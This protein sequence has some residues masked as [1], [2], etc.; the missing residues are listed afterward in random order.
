MNSE[1]EQNFWIEHIQKAQSQEELA[2][3]REALDVL[4]V[5]MLRVARDRDNEEYARWAQDFFT[6][7][8]AAIDK[9]AKQVPA[10]T[11]VMQRAFWPAL[12]LGVA[13]AGVL[14]VVLPFAAVPSM[15]V[16]DLVVGSIALG[17]GTLD[18]TSKTPE[19]VHDVKTSASVGVVDQYQAAKT[20]SVLLGC[21]LTVVGGIGLTGILPPV[22]LAIAAGFAFGPVAVDVYDRYITYKETKQAIKIAEAE[23]AEQI[24][25][26]V[27]HEDTMDL[28]IVKSQQKTL[29]DD[30]PDE[31]SVCFIETME[32]NMFAAF[33][34]IQHNVL[35][36]GSTST[37]AIPESVT[38]AE[39]G[40][41]RGLTN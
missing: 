21:G 10:K 13:V 34:K 9:R 40:A 18:F 3:W 19:L 8:R 38:E 2:V 27:E 17:H 35:K 24:Q 29:Q 1:N 41:F 36:S 14:A 4:S 39:A 30:H 7:S 20:M 37:T 15:H 11:A 22:A 33:E 25:H 16:I 6:R 23:S 26:F 28:T 5:E 32:K 31:N 12:G